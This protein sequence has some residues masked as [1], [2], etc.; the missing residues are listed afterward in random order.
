MAR[1]AR[2]RERER[3]PVPH[4]LVQS[5]HAANELTEQGVRSV[6][7][8]SDVVVGGALSYCAAVHTAR[9]SHVRSVVAV[10]AV[11]SHCAAPHTVSGSQA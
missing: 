6:H 5:L 2:L 11:S 10:A 7:S 9:A 4:D 8:R 1:S 3:E